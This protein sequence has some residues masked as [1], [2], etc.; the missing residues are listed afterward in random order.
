MKCGESDHRVLDFHHRDSKD[1]MFNISDF[2]HRVGFVKLDAEMRK[3]VL[4]CANCH[5]IEHYR[6]P[7]VITGIGA[8]G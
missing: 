4:V 1:K 3:C 2:R 6:E 8:V 5:R 7:E